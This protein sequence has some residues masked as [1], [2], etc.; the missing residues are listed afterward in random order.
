MKIYYLN[1]L[2]FEPFWDKKS[3]VNFKEKGKSPPLPCKPRCKKEENVYQNLKDLLEL[4]TAKL[5]SPEGLILICLSPR[6][7]RSGKIPW[8]GRNIE[9]GE[10]GGCTENSS[11]P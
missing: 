2:T 7:T 6:L 9:E 10:L 8:G 4:L 11:D 1:L 3:F 5:F